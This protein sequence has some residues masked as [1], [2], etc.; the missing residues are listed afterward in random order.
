MLQ[1]T[2]TGAHIYNPTRMVG[3]KNEE[4]KV[5]FGNTKSFR[6]PWAAGDP[7]PNKQTKNCVVWLWVLMGPAGY[8]CTGDCRV[9]AK[10]PARESKGPH[11]DSVILD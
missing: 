8:M 3:Q 5:I 9:E 4:F 11:S 1:V 6:P 7:D 10:R 2:R